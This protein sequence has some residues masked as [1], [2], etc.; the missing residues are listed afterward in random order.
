MVVRRRLRSGRPP[1]CFCTSYLRIRS[2]TRRHVRRTAKHAMKTVKMPA[3]LSPALARWRRGSWRRDATIARAAMW[4]Y[5]PKKTM[6]N[7]FRVLYCQTVLQRRGCPRI[8]SVAKAEHVVRLGTEE[9]HTSDDEGNW[10]RFNYTLTSCI[11]C[12]VHTLLF[13]CCR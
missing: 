11:P 7:P 12:D 1:R 2:C 10:L 8:A 13:S 4:P 3:L 9:P 5:S 6:G